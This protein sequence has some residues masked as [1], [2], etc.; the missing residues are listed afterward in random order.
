MPRY[1]YTARSKTGKNVRGVIDGANETTVALELIKMGTTPI[2]IEI[3]KEKA[4]TFDQIEAFLRIN[5][6]GLA[7]LT[8]FSRQMYTLIRA[9]VP[10][11]RAVHVVLDSSKNFQ[12][13]MALADVLATIEGG[14]S[15]GNGLRKHP[16]IFPS[17][18]VALVV[19]GENTG[20]LD[21][22]FRQISVHLDREIDTRKQ[23]KTATRYP[24]MVLSIIAVA[25]TVINLIVI[26]AFSK[27]FT[28]FKVEL[29]LPTQ[30][31]IATSNFF[32]AYWY[33]ML[34]AIIASII[35]F[36]LYLKTKKGRYAWDKL[37]LHFPI[38]GSIINRSLLARF[39][40]SFALSIRTGVPL[41]EAVGLIAKSTD[42]AFVSEQ[43]ITMRTYIEHGE[44]L[45]NAA[46]K[47]GMFTPLVLQMLAI[48]EET[49][50]IDRLLDEVANYYEQEVDYA[51]KRLG[52]A[53]EPIL[54]VV[55]GVMVLI[56]ALGVFI[57]LWDIWKVAA[58]K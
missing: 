29:P 26:P 23:I 10:M 17:L 21:E 44:S 54:I 43:I 18:M 27:F 24:I 34:G 5:K 6:P 37:K 42:N 57:P 16:E 53:I 15:L 8:F 33:I 3:Y 22:V 25:M 4:T 49:G 45:T 51:V 28:Q 58:V 1:E 47:T 50:E 31:L 14:Q 32:V 56:L 46:T 13:K 40:R 55:L 48:G 12:L 52:D 20:S 41:L 39:A 19:V 35:I 38:I 30:I 9:G 7:D 36:I 11:V 2:S